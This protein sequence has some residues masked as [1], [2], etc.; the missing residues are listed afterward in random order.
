MILQVMEKSGKGCRVIAE[1]Q[2]VM[3]IVKSNSFACSNLLMPRFH[4]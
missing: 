3:V 2:M 1:A 4:L